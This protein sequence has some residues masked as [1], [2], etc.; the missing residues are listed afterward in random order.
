M[1][2]EEQFCWI[3]MNIKD[4]LRITNIMEMAL[5]EINKIRWNLLANG[6][7][8]NLFEVSSIIANKT[9]HKYN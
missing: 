2:K 9:I 4:F 7:K 6:S 8:A 3:G 1:E 5:L